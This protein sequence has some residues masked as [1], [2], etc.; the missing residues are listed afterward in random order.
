MSHI[1]KDI[2]G[3]RK[4]NAPRPIGHDIASGDCLSVYLFPD[5]EVEWIWS[6][7][8]NGSRHVIGYKIKKNYE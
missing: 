8:L 3:R 2:L 1:E 4:V 6:I 5:E 7:G